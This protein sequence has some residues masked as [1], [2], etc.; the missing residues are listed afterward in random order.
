MKA[1]IVED[2]P[3]SQELLR[4][5]ADAAF[6]GIVPVCVSEVR[7]ALALPAAAFRLALVDLSLPD[8]SGLA[9]IERLAAQ[10]PECTVVVTTIHDDD[11]H[12][13]AALRAGAHGYLHKDEPPEQLARQLQGIR[14]GRPPLSPAIARRILGYFHQ[15]E[16]PAAAPEVGL[17]PREREVLTRLARGLSIAAI[18]RELAISHHTVGDHVKNIYRKLN[19]SSRAEAALQAKQLGLL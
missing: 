12:V 18:A 10:A 5:L 19:I 13:F 7:A 8:G 2:V 3:E 1:L 9:V 14:E 6:P 17:T 4:E 15:R 16:K 11:D